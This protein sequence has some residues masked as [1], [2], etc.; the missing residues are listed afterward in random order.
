MNY[1]TFLASD[2]PIPHMENPHQQFLSI[3]EA[4]DKGIAIPK[5]MLDSS[6]MAVHIAIFM[7]HIQSGTVRTQL[8]RQ[9]SS[10]NPLL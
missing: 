4:I 9:M 1:A 6:T 2:A 8:L 7:G 5:P 10:I 3:N